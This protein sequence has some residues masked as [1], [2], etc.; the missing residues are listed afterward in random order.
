MQAVFQAEFPSTVSASNGRSLVHRRLAVSS[1]PSTFCQRSAVPEVMWRFGPC[2]VNTDKPVF[3][4]AGH[5]VC[6]LPF[7]WLPSLKISP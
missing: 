4:I 1:L 3:Q 6:D 7:L 5:R 2:W